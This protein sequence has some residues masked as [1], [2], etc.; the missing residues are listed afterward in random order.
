MKK[1]LLLFAAV[2][3][4]SSCGAYKRL[5][6]LQ[7]MNPEETYEVSQSYETRIGRG[8]KLGISVMSSQPILAA[9]FNVRPEVV[10]KDSSAVSQNAPVP[11]YTVDTK[12]RINFPVLGSI[13][14]EG[15]TLNELSTLL[16]DEIRATN[17]LKDPVVSIS[18]TNFRILVL[19]ESNKRD[20]LTFPQG[21]VTIFDL[22]ASAGDITQD[23]DREKMW[24]IRTVGGSRKLFELN[25]KSKSIFDSPAYYLQQNDMVILQPRNGK[26]DNSVQNVITWVTTPLSLLSTIFS[27]W[28]LVRT[29]TR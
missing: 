16:V 17:Y 21:N 26:M 6:Y 2:A 25:A 3:A 10:V 29:Y 12:G 1:L 22:L 7:D 8:D 20:I 23:A 14:V 18:F 28:A 4:L 11:E 24:V 5:A 27:G 9:P 19:G 15:L 13:Y